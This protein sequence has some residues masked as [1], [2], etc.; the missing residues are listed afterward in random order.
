MQQWSRYYSLSMVSTY[1][2]GVLIVH[3]ARLEIAIENGITSIHAD[4]TFLLAAWNESLW[5]KSHLSR[6]DTVW[7]LVPN[8]LIAIAPTI[9]SLIVWFAAHRRDTMPASSYNKTLDR[10]NPLRTVSSP[11][12][13]RVAARG[14]NVTTHDLREYPADHRDRSKFTRSDDRDLLFDYRDIFES[15]YRAKSATTLLI[16]TRLLAIFLKRKTVTGA[17]HKLRR[18]RAPRVVLVILTTVDRARLKLN[19]RPSTWTSLVGRCYV[20]RRVRLIREGAATSDSARAIERASERA[21]GSG[22][23]NG[24]YR[25]G[26]YTLATGTPGRFT[27]RARARARARIV[28]LVCTY[29]FEAERTDCEPR[30]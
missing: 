29:T 4:P 8:K 1:L 23:G 2:V 13:T 9:P 5:M 21:N 12:A 6:T 10:F 7:Q 26:G 3:S 11:I 17:S 15:F 27:A 18:S 19:C 28:R 25:V 30:L 22:S 24:N 16:F 20:R 14:A